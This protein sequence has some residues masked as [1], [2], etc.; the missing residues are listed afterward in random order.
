MRTLYTT[1]TLTALLTAAACQKT[2]LERCQAQLDGSA[3]QHNADISRCFTD[4]D[5]GYASLASCKQENTSFSA[6]YN[7]I[8]ESMLNVTKDLLITATGAKNTFG[9]ARALYEASRHIVPKDT[10]LGDAYLMTRY[11]VA[12]FQQD[13]DLLK[14]TEKDNLGWI[15]HSKANIEK[16]MITFTPNTTDGGQ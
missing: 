4:L 16:W 12:Q 10:T 11:G 1:I 5:A 6:D 2:E 14:A 15:S 8:K 7:I 9:V 3:Q 13:A